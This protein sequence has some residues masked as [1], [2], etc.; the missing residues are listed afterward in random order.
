MHEVKSI[1]A[2]KHNIISSQPVA[3]ILIIGTKRRSDREIMDE[4]GVKKKGLQGAREKR[5]REREGKSQGARQ[6]E[7][8]SW[9]EEG[10]ERVGKRGE[11]K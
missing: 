10:R 8:E 7:K 2:S 11:M 9:S 6:T 5:L 4:R 3:D 1:A